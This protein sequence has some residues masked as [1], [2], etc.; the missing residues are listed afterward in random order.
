MIT[1][2]LLLTAISAPM[3][4]GPLLALVSGGIPYTPAAFAEAQ[5][6]G[7]SIL[8]IVHAPWCPT[9]KV[10]DPIIQKLLGEAKYKPV[11][12]FIVDF[13]TQKDALRAFNAPKQSTLIGFKGMKETNRSSGN[14]SPL[15]IEDLIESTL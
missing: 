14:T 10:Q 2:R 8:V 6:A 13:D 5:K 15:D 7:K 9:C 12:V 4:A 1:R 3:M 11:T